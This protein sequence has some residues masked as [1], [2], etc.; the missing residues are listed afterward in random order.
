MRQLASELA[1]PI[2]CGTIRAEGIVGSLRGPAGAYIHVPF[3]EQLCPFC[4]YNKEL[5]HSDRAA[6]YYGALKDEL[7]L[8]RRAVARPFASLYIGGGTPTISIDRLAE[9]VALVPTTGERAVELHPRQATPDRI[10]ALIGMGINFVSLGIQS[11][12]E[13]TLRHLCRPTSPR[14]NLQALEN[15]LGRFA[16]LDVDLIFDVAFQL[17]DVFLADL[18]RRFRAGVDQV[19]TYPLMRFGFTPFGKAKHFPRAEHQVLRRATDLA[20]CWGYERRSVWTFNRLGTRPYTSITRP[21]YI[22]MG[23]GSASYTGRLFALNEFDVERY[24]SRVFDEELPIPRASRLGLLPASA[25]YVFWQA[26]TGALDVDEVA[27]RFG[28]NAGLF[29]RGISNVLTKRGYFERAGTRYRLTP[30]GFD[31][32]HDL[33]RWVTYRFIEPL[34]RDMTPHKRLVRSDRCRHARA[35]APGWAR[36]LANGTCRMM[37]TPAL[38]ARTC[39]LA[40]LGAPGHRRRSGARSQAVGTCKPA[41]FPGRWCST[42]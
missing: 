6:R 14:D 8:Y 13:A 30:T 41:G 17:P 39:F 27:L 12:D 38:R 24:T 2:G 31:R 25:Y 19:S 37:E 29:W 23:A 34:W 36:L 9:I 5:Y 35:G 40:A 1:T 32:Y 4:P 15:S 18:E 20:R 42:G 33:E 3:C 28:R 26:Y 7:R 16:C 21:F 22:G 10:N 11:F